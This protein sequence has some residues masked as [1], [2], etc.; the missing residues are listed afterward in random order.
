MKSCL[1]IG[2]RGLLGLSSDIAEK[3]DIVRKA[4]ERYVLPYASIKEG[5]EALRSLIGYDERAWITDGKLWWDLAESATKSSAHV[6]KE[7]YHQFLANSPVEPLFFYHQHSQHKNYQLNPPTPSDLDVCNTLNAEAQREVVCRVVEPKVIW[8]YGKNNFRNSEANSL[9]LHHFP[10][11]AAFFVELDNIVSEE[12][13]EEQV[14]AVASLY[15][16]Y[17]VDLKFRRLKRETENDY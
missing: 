10:Y 4:E 13:S 9:L 7:R 5:E 16:D 11:P 8:E 12:F 17:G 14:L 6:S 1:L 3:P 15:A 2:L